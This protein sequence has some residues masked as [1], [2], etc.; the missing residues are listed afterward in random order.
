MATWYPGEDVLGHR[1]RVG[2]SYARTGLPGVTHERQLRRGQA[3]LS[4]WA[5]SP[6]SYDQNN[7]LGDGTQTHLERARPAC[8]E[9]WAGS[10]RRRWDGGG[11][12]AARR[13]SLDGASIV[14]KTLG[15]TPTGE[16]AARGTVRR[17]SAPGTTARARATC[18]AMAW[19]ARWAC[20]THPA[21]RQPTTP[22]SHSGEPQS[23][24]TGSA[25]P[26]APGVRT[27]R[28][29]AWTLPR[30]LLPPEAAALRGTDEFA[31]CGRSR[32]GT[33]A[34]RGCWASR[35]SCSPSTRWT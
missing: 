2:G 16:P 29:P 15:S 7:L 17:A 22:T 23:A 5:G 4:Q 30:P 31:A 26:P 32:A 27:T 1:A 11:A 6:L 10:L 33:R 8:H 28:H 14:Q 18:C 34:S 21:P 13:P 19:G 24:G 25:T 35:T 3:Q 12:R 20:W 9:Q